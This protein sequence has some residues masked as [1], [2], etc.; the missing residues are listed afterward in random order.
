MYWRKRFKTRRISTIATE[1]KRPANY[2][3]RKRIH[4]QTRLGNASCLWESCME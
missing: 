3:K 4:T 2:R 1:W